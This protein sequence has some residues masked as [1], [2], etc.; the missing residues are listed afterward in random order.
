MSSNTHAFVLLTVNRFRHGT[1]PEKGPFRTP[2]ML[3]HILR[4][5]PHSSQASNKF[6][7]VFRQRT[8]VAPFRPSLFICLG[9]SVATFATIITIH[10]DEAQAPARN[11]PTSIKIPKSS[12]QI[13]L[14][15]QKT[16]PSP[17]ADETFDSSSGSGIPSEKAI[18]I[19]RVD[20]ILLARYVYETTCP[21]YFVRTPFLFR[22]IATN[23]AKTS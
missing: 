13:Y 17:T 18:G 23:P 20:T 1:P 6:S 9:V 4:L 7:P 19:S 5:L 11:D 15:P 16:P 3:R 8:L 22:L 14:L 10:G 12:F 2:I 21:F